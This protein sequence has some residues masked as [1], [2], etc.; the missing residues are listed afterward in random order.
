MKTAEENVCDIT[1]GINDLRE[2]EL[3]ADIIETKKSNSYSKHLFDKKLR[4]LR[5]ELLKRGMFYCFKCDGIKPTSDFTKSKSSSLGLFCY[6]KQCCKILYHSFCNKPKRKEVR[7]IWSLREKFGISL[8]RYKE[9]LKEQNYQ[10][11][12]CGRLSESEKDKRMLAV[13]HDHKTK[14]VRGI[15]CSNCNNGLGRFF[16]NTKYLSKA[17]DYLNKYNNES[18]PSAN[19][20]SSR[21]RGTQLLPGSPLTI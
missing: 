5:I 21:S 3:L 8:D 7:K 4:Q 13:D 14:K 2:K 1:I 12:I 10:C 18:L 16:D 9:I 17:I 15:L 19:V 6:C 11:A 20:M